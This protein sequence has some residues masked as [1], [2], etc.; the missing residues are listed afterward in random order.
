M[1]DIG[2]KNR[3]WPYTSIFKGLTARYSDDPARHHLCP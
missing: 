1:S 3:C 2:H